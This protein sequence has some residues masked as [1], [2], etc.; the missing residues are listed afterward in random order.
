M[1]ISVLLK[2]KHIFI[3]IR[4]SAQCTLLIIQNVGDFCKIKN[5]VVRRVQPDWTQAVIGWEKTLP[6]H[7]SI[8]PNFNSNYRRQSLEQGYR[9]IQAGT[10]N[11]KSG[12]LKNSWVLNSG[13]PSRFFYL[14]LL[15]YWFYTITTGSQK[16]SS[17]LE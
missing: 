3:I 13:C 17:Q 14:I 1:A 4:H 10:K 7:W 8:T 16:Y 6:T 5:G 15:F 11:L 12:S 9:L 2:T